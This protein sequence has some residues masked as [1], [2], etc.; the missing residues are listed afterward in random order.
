MSLN[1][2]RLTAVLTPTISAAFIAGGAIASPQLL[3]LSA[4]LAAAIA[5]GVI[6]EI[7]ANAIVPGTG[8]GSPSGAVTGATTVT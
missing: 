4:Q 2:A 3:A 6:A 8:L 1:A 7:T 5:T